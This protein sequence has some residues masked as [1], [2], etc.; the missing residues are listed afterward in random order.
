MSEAPRFYILHGDDDISLRGA[1]RQ[2]RQALGDDGELNYSELDGAS[3]TVPEALS[4]VRS[5]PFLAD[6]RLVVARGLISHITR[7][8]AGQPGKTAVARLLDGLAD[9]PAHARLALVEDRLLSDGN[10]VLKRAREIDHGYIRAFKTPQNLSGW[11]IQRANADYAADIKPAAATAI[12]ALAKD[13]VLL[14]DSELAKLAAFVDGERPI[15]EDDVADLTPYV[16]EANVFEMADALAMGDGERAQRLIG[17]ALRDDPRDPGFRLFSLIVRQFRLLLMAKDYLAGGGSSQPHD[18]AKALGVRHFVAGK[19][20]RQ[21][22]AYSISQL[23]RV[24]RHLQ[25]V[26]QDVK[27]G[28]MELR[29]ALDLL[30][31]SLARR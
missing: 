16:P 1:L 7:R 23:E 15:S 28:R 5:M 13:D 31:A 17:R 20:A 3:V 11:I 25:R 8:G 26:D 10:P 18:M 22:N 27:T 30:V 24:L 12:A 2:M 21:A 14:A 9:L 19:L 6:K 29:L 4:A